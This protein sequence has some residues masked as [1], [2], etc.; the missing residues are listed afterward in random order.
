MQLLSLFSAVPKAA[1]LIHLDNYN[2]PYSL[3]SMEFINLT[4]T[5]E[6][7]VLQILCHYA[8]TFFHFP[9]DRF[10]VLNQ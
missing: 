6:S 1:G 5:R 9:L 7:L 3:L 4:L 8:D 10:H 2:D